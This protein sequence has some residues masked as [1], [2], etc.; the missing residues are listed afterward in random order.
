MPDLRHIYRNLK[1]KHIP[2]KRYNRKYDPKYLDELASKGCSV[3]LGFGDFDGDYDLDGT[4][5]KQRAGVAEKPGIYTNKPLRGPHSMSAMLLPSEGPLFLGST[6]I[7]PALG[8]A[9]LSLSL[10]HI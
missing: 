6:I 1:L 4:Y 2:S 10:I 5:P 9:E 7:K 3:K 8:P